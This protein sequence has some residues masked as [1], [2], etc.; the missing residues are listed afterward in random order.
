ME[1]FGD[2]H[3]ESDDE[4]VDSYINKVLMRK[5]PKI[6][7]PNIFYPRKMKTD[8]MV[9]KDQIDYHLAPPSRNIDDE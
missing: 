7:E 5:V 2:I 9:V 3:S 4:E 8:I 6:E 1:K